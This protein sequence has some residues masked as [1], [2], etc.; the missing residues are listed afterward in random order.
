MYSRRI[1]SV[2]LF[3]VVKLENKTFIWQMRLLYSHVST[4]RTPS[5]PYS[6][7]VASVFASIDCMGCRIDQKNF[8]GN[9]LMTLLS[10]VKLAIQSITA[11]LYSIK[12]W[13]IVP[14]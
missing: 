8:H 13:S 11:K 5:A 10:D 14:T 9:A 7:V 12:K 2:E 1:C 6:R 4:P 3:I